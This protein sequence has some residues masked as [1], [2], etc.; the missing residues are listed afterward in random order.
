MSG[1]SYIIDSLKVVYSEHF[2]SDSPWLLLF[3]VQSH[4]FK[5]RVTVFIVEPL[6]VIK[7]VLFC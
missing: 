3:Q 1:E 2:Y 6:F 4:C 7:W 5:C